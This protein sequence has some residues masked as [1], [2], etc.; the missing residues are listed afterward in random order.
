M[1]EY[2]FLNDFIRHYNYSDKISFYNFADL[3]ENQ[4]KKYGYKLMKEI[5]ENLLS[6]PLYDR[7]SYLEYVEERLNK[8]MLCKI[9]TSLMEKWILE[10]DLKD[11]KFPYEE[12]LELFEILK[13]ST[14]FSNLNQ[15]EIVRIENIQ[16]DFYIYAYYLEILKV[17][18]FIEN[19]Y[20]SL[21]NNDGKI[22]WIGKPSHLG[23]IIGKLVE[24]EYVESPKKKNGDINYTQLAKLV[25]SN[26]DLTT[27]EETLSKYLNLESEKGNETLRKFEKSKFN[28]PHRK[29]M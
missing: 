15:N 22:K 12:N 28:L 19:K 5:S 7:K 18:E 11:N 26:F 6:L 9:D 27:T 16:M 8:E 25:Y 23:F 13:T 3:Y 20:H 21:I 29:E 1:N 14:E 24:M 4:I 17:L 10:F 2:T